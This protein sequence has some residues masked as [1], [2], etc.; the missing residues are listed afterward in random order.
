[1]DQRSIADVTVLSPTGRIDLDTTPPLQDCLLPLTQVASAKVV[2]DFAGVSYIS[3][4]G[5]RA[6]ML[7]AKAARA[8][9]GRL[10][11]CCLNPAVAEIFRISRFHLVV[12]VQNDLAAALAALSSSAAAAY[13]HG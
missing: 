8:A 7:G 3:S 5:L 11:V 1:M 9:Q 6:L 13:R 4:S 12:E 2:V 10:V